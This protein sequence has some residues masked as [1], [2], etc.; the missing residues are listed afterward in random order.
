MTPSRGVVL[1]TGKPREFDAFLRA[2]ARR[3]EA[4]LDERLRLDRGPSTLLRAMRYA[5]F[6]GGKR[7][8]P[9]LVY[10]G[11]RTFG[12][13]LSRVDGAAAAVEMIHTY[14]LIHDDLP[15]MDDDDLRRGR[16]T[17]HVKFGEAMAVLAGDALHT[18]AFATIAEMSEVESCQVLTRILA[19]AAGPSGMVGG[20]VLD[21]RAEG[22]P[23]RARRVEEIHL[24]KTAALI[25]AALEMGAAGAGA[26]AAD[27]ARIR[28]F[29]RDVGL[30][31]QVADDILDLTSD[32]A[33][34]GK[35]P[36]KDVVA[37]KMT[38]PAAIGL[39]KSRQRAGA[40][41]ARAQ[42][43]AQDLP[44]DTRSLLRTLPLF[45]TRRSK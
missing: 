37:G 8:R 39:R 17:L 42:R 31:F 12:G 32:A 44:R 6:G 33:T 36:G 28:R 34:L 2:S 45:V 1:S 15:C 35:T 5:V 13:P 22:R 29:G 41:A 7:F 27:R 38:Y 21:L 25:A 14:S 30:A 40:L 11:C 3:V 4:V 24:G 26:S 19:R 9:A 16:P 20:Q 18:E 10:L 43:M 23:P